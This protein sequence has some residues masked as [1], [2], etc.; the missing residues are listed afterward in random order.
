[1]DGQRTDAGP[2]AQPESNER[3]SEE[4]RRARALLA[5]RPGAVR[6]ERAVGDADRR[7][8]EHRSEVE[9]EACAPRMVAPRAVDKQHIRGEFEGENGCGERRPFAE[10]EQSRLV[11]RAGFGFHHDRFLRGRCGAPERVT[12]GTGAVLP[13]DGA[14]EAAADQ[15]VC[16]GL[17]RRRGGLGELQLML[18]ELVGRRR[19]GRHGGQDSS[20]S[21]R[22]AN[23]GL[24][25]ALRLAG[26]S[27]ARLLEA[28]GHLPRSEFVPVALADQADLDAPL[29]I[30]HGQVTT[31]PSLV[32]RMV[33]ALALTGAERVLEVGTGYG[34][35]TALLSR[36]A[37]EVW[38]IERWPD[39]ADTAR[40]HLARRGAENATVVVG[41]GS[42][43]LP[44]HAPYDAI[45]VSAA[46]PEVPDPL[47]AQL[48]VGGRLVQPIGPG[49]REDVV[50]FERLPKGLVARRTI[51]GAHF[52]RL[53][54]RRAFPA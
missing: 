40:Q 33:E 16:A 38:S 9:R 39:L 25:E 53:V 2:R 37:R 50:L 32:A 28:V 29:A 5:G 23:V 7:Q 43:G 34:W 17:P 46:F 31:Q 22:T 13:T 41:D 48:A 4:Q 49:G 20:V 18:D 51:V 42:E 54:G 15:R 44:E 52:V 10:R 36:L 35:Q 26:V 6:D 21:A 45:L 24:L 1:V 8:V 3:S 47:V 12:G 19:P 27:D 30:P 11:R 14:D